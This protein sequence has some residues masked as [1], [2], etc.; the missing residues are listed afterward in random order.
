MNQLEKQKQL[1]DYAKSLEGKTE[2]ELK[3]LEQ[4]IIKEADQTDK[5]VA[6]YEFKLSAKNYKEVA[7]AI[8]ALLN[9]QTVQWQYTLGMVSMYDFWDPEKCPK[10]V[11]YPILDTTLRTLGNMQFTGYQEWAY[12]VAINKYFEPIRE[13]YSDV[14]EKVFDVAAKHN[15]ILDR[16]KLYEPIDSQ[17]MIVE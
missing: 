7:E 11:K 6:E 2:E 14:T 17:Q 10:K 12:V 13:E 5:D 4:E 3:A 8:R 15:A 9:N 16:L 1:E